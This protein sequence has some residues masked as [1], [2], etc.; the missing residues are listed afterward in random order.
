M[1]TNDFQLWPENNYYGGLHVAD[2]WFN[3]IW[4]PFVNS[5]HL[6]NRNDGLQD[7]AF[8]YIIFWNQIYFVLRVHHITRKW[9]E[10]EMR[11]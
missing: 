1:Q 6:L 2:G 9:R 8:L 3:Y 11:V 4:E 5:V 10:D 7:G